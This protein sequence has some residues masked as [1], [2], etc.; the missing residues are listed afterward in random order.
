MLFGGFGAHASFEELFLPALESLA[1][2]S[3]VSVSHAEPFRRVRSNIALRSLGLAFRAI[4]STCSS[5]DR[6]PLDILHPLWS[7]VKYPGI[8]SIVVELCWNM[9]DLDI[10]IKIDDASFGL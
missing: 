2:S 5:L 4:D 3:T 8:S 7:T 9:I 6:A 10:L 1:I